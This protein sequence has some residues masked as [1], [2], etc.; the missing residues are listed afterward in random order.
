MKQREK[1]FNQLLMCFRDA[2]EKVAYNLA[3]YLSDSEY[4]SALDLMRD[5]GAFITICIKVDEMQDMPKK[6][7][8]SELFEAMKGEIINLILP[9]EISKQ[10]F[11]TIETS[12]EVDNSLEVD[13]GKCNLV[14]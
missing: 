7:T 6:Y 10:V 11:S 12:T 2:G 13:T 3:D 1:L 9:I 8:A 5:K 4:K 14:N